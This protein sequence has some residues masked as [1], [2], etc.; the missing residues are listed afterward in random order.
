[1]PYQA[2]FNYPHMEV[3]GV[4]TEVTKDYWAKQT[5]TTEDYDLFKAAESR[6]QATW[7][8]VISS[9]QGSITPMPDDT[10]R[11]ILQQPILNDPEFV[12]YMSQMLSDP[13]VTWPGPGIKPSV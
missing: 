9:G 2:F 1:M 7:D 4:V 10:I 6:E 3:D 13:A 11:I 8:Q 12:K 5:L